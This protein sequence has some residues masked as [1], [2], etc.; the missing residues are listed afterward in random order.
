MTIGSCPQPSEASRIP[1]RQIKSSPASRASVCTE[2]REAIVGRARPAMRS[3][4]VP[5]RGS[6][7]SSAGACTALN[8][9]SRWSPIEAN[10]PTFD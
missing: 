3:T 7:Q 1:T 6:G 4:S 8:R 10:L 9:Y 5:G 2:T